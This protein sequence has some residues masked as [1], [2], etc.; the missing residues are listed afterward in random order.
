MP[1]TLAVLLTALVVAGVV[2]V[3]SRS[4][5][6]PDPVDPEP[7]E[8]WLVRLVGRYQLPGSASPVNPSLPVLGSFNF[9]DMIFGPDGRMWLGTD[10]YQGVAGQRLAVYQVDPD[11]GTASLTMVTSPVANRQFTA[12]NMIEDGQLPE[13]VRPRKG[14]VLFPERPLFDALRRLGAVV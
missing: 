13:P 2:W 7:E 4:P 14:V 1:V 11:N 10:T 3:L 6:V 12:I 9:L 5:A 8:R